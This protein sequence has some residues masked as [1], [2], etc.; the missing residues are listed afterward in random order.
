MSGNVSFTRLEVK[1]LI[2]VY[3]LVKDCCDGDFAIKA[4]GDV[5]LPRPNASDT[6]K[7]NLDRYLAYLDRARFYNV[8]KNTLAGLLG[9]IFSKKSQIEISAELEVLKTNC[10]GKGNGIEQLAKQGISSLLKSGRFGLFTDFPSVDTEVSQDEV[11]DLDIRPVIRLYDSRD[12]INW[13]II[14][15]GAEIIYSLIVLKERY[16]WLFDE[17]QTRE[18]NRYRV[19]KLNETGDYQVDIYES[20]IQSID[21]TNQ[22]TSTISNPVFNL[23]KSYIPKDVDG[24]FIKRI[25]FEFCGTE[26]NVAD[27]NVPILYD[28]AS[29]NIGHYRNSADYEESCYIVGQPT[30][31][32]TGLTKEW[33]ENVLKGEIQLGSRAGVMLPISATAGILQAAPNTMPIEAMKHKETQF[34]AL[35]AKLVTPGSSYNTATEAEMN[36]TS[37]GSILSTLAV[38]ASICFENAIKHCKLFIKST[39]EAMFKLNTDFEISKLTVAER[40]QLLKEWQGEAISF[41]EYRNNLRAGKVEL[42][43]DKIAVTEMETDKAQEL[44]DNAANGLDANGQAIQQLDATAQQPMQGNKKMPPNVGTKS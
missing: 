14:F 23:V 37:E 8:T 7:E 32:F 15:V 21:P 2:A 28:I 36:N 18:Q 41:T 13:R 12:I 34:L 31:Y 10:D 43:E 33:V 4:R 26:S 22:S 9:Q 42:L 3:D 6:T 19:L 40:Q 29:L 30:T 27:P 20:D 1:N 16:I 25:P 5:Y 11:F 17:F 39:A 24:N 38:N 44:A 35:G